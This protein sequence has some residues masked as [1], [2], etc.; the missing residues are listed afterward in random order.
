[1]FDPE[2]AK[3]TRERDHLHQMLERE[4]WVFGEQYNMMISERSL[5]AVLDRHLALL[6]RTREDKQ[7]VTRMDGTIGRV[8]LMLSAAATEHDRNRHLVIELKAPKVVATEV[9]LRQIKGASGFSV[10][11]VWF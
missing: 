6:G 11:S 2:T 3:L 7:V 8:D 10:G 4:L 1:V 9:E 5:T